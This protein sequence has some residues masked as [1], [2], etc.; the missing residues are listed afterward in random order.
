L[1]P[2][3]SALPVG[4]QPS[5]IS[6]PNDI[7]MYYVPASSG[8]HVIQVRLN[9]EQLKC[10]PVLIHDLAVEFAKPIDH[11]VPTGALTYFEAF[12]VDA[13][14]KERYSLPW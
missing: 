10:F 14:T 3:S 4:K 12:F 11:E 5:H 7:S 1:Q 6:D 8:P 2:L 13:V 9:G